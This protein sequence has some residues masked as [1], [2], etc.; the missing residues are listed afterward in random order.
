MNKSPLDV[1]LDILVQPIDIGRKEWRSAYP[2]TLHAKETFCINNSRDD[3]HIIAR[4]DLEL[5]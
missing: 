2:P 5:I 3:F 4:A 1:I